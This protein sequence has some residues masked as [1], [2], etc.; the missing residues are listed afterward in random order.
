MW[1]FCWL[2]LFCFTER[3]K[4]PCNFQVKLFCKPGPPRAAVLQVAIP[5][6]VWYFDL[7]RLVSFV[8]CVDIWTAICQFVLLKWDDSMIHCVIRWLQQ[9]S[10]SLSI[11]CIPM[12]HGIKKEFVPFSRLG[13]HISLKRLRALCETTSRTASRTTHCVDEWYFF[14]SVLPLPKTNI[15]SPWKWMVGIR[16]FPFGIAHF[17]GLC[18]FQGGYQAS[19]WGPRYPKWVFNLELSQEWPEE[20]IWLANMGEKVG[21]ERITGVTALWTWCLQVAQEEQERIEREKARIQKQELPK[22]SC[23]NNFCFV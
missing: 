1:A 18:K 7:L 20:P 6:P 12:N 9:V 22:N 2:D 14:F 11:S 8:T 16:S 4:N 13:M 21:P 5:Y 15:I 17:Q 23:N 19:P 3:T 10:T